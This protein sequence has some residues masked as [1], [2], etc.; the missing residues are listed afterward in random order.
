MSLNTCTRTHTL[1][2]QKLRTTLLEILNRLPFNE[3]LREY[4]PQILSLMM[5]LLQIENEE[6]A[7]ICLRIIIGMFQFPVL[8]LVVQVCACWGEKN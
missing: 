6:N 8:P 3:A 2:P 7:V 5:K 1:P 4:V